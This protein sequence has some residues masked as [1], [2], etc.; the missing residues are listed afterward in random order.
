MKPQKVS[1]MRLS[2]GAA[3]RAGLPP[4]YN[5]YSRVKAEP[6][7]DGEM[8]DE[9]MVLFPLYATSFCLYDYMKDKGWF[10]AEQVII[11]SASSKTAIGTAYAIAGEQCRAAACGPHLSAQSQGG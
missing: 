8:D 9:R 11:P 6:G 10:G 2:D 5:A 1:E 4:V 3:H 7:Y